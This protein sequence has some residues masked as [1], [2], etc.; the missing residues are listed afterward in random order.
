MNTKDEEAQMKYLGDVET[1]ARMLEGLAFDHAREIG[2][3]QVAMLIE[4]AATLD[5]IVTTRAQGPMAELA[6]RTRARLH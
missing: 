4:M 2:I 5:R 6:G 3:A 1:A